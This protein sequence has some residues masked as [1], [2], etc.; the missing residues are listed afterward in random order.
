MRKR[1]IGAL[2]ITAII[3]LT[4]IGCSTSNKSNKEE[5][6]TEGNDN[7]EIYL[8]KETEKK[9]T[10][11]N[12]VATIEMEDGKVIKLELYP[13]IAPNTVRNFIS[14]ANSKFYDGLIFHRVI[15]GFMI[16][17]G[18]PEGTGMGGPD[19]SIYGEFANNQFENNLL[20]TKGVISM[21]R[22]NDK[23]SAGSQFFIMH[24]DT[25][26]LDGD[27]AAFGK[28]IE[29]M[30]VVDSIAQIE[31]G[32]NDRP[33]KDIKI[34]SITVDTFGVTYNEPVKYTK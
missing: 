21:A 4:L 8:S 16:Q 27:Y 24:G 31:T 29:G 15:S 19:Y 5:A 2:L 20:H 10:D 6:N 17:G 25:P 13:E 34:K 22:S 28:V 12:P 18:D 3:S 7:K 1:T 32:S 33:K 9:E 30:N 23:N 11:K 26:S 14:L